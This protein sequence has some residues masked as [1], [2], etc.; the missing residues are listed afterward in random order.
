[1]GED[2]LGQFLGSLQRRV[3]GGV[4]EGMESPVTEEEVEE[5]MKGL[6]AGKVPGIDGLPKDFFWDFG[7]GCVG[8]G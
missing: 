1:V 6:P 5:A 8:G 2:G 4:V 7:E 3:P